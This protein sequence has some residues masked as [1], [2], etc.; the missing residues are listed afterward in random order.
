MGKI[1][2]NNKIY[3]PH[4]NKKII[5]LNNITNENIYII[6]LSEY[7][8][9]NGYVTRDNKE[10]NYTDNDYT[11]AM[12]NVLGIQ[13]AIKYAESNGYDSVVLPKGEYSVCYSQKDD[14]CIYVGNVNFDAKD[15]TFKVIFD[16]NNFN[17][18]DSKYRT[19]K[20]PDCVNKNT[21]VLFNDD[22]TCPSCGRNYVYDFEKA[23]FLISFKKSSKGKKIK[24]LNLIGDRFERTWRDFDK[25]SQVFDCEKGQDGTYGIRLWGCNNTLENIYSKGFMGD[26]ITSNNELTFEKW[27]NGSRPILGIYEGDTSETPITFSLG[28]L[29]DNGDE[30]DNTQDQINNKSMSLRTPYYEINTKSFEGGIQRLL[31]YRGSGYTRIARNNH[32]DFHAYFFDTDYNLINHL[33]VEPWE[34]FEVPLNAKYIRG[35]LNYQNSNS[36]SYYLGYGINYGNKI[37]NCIS[38]E[39]HRGGLTGGGNDFIFDNIKLLNN[40]NPIDGIVFPDTTRYGYNQEDSYSNKVTIRNSTIENSFNPILFG[41]YNGIIDNCVIKG[42][43]GR[44]ITIYENKNMTIKNNEI[45]GSIGFASNSNPIPRNVDIYNNIL[46]DGGIGLNLTD[47]CNFHDNIVTMDS[48]GITVTCKNIS[49]NTFNQTEGTSNLPLNINDYYELYG[50]IF[51]KILLMRILPWKTSNGAYIIN[52]CVFNDCPS[53]EHGSN[54]N[55][56]YKDCELNNSSIKCYNPS[57]DDSS[58]QFNVTCIRTKFND[59]TIIAARMINIPNTENVYKDVEFNFCEINNSKIGCLSNLS[60]INPMKIIFNNCTFNYNCTFKKFQGST[61]TFYLNNCIMNLDELITEYPIILTN[62]EFKKPIEETEFI[63]IIKK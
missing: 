34:N 8:I 18:Y 16:S 55:I 3:F 50:N 46:I 44:A 58:K 21:K 35:A 33:I 52:S 5:G 9:T 62:C 20:N 29:D 12:N 59:S 25:K 49:N 53:I 54:I 30:F 7:N 43:N 4:L 1:F 32:Q 42:N 2:I 57:T 47:N 11:I 14:T 63:T 10:T 19:C 24:N 51:N 60:L 31:C 23:I 40:A 28:G 48:M 26:N 17:P 39:G 6:P 37:I 36:Y 41:V 61:F 27:I 45:T 38:E 22:G 15:S 13:N 56:E